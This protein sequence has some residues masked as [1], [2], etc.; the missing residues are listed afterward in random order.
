MG[1]LLTSLGFGLITASILAIA[2]VGFTLQFGITNLL[3]L[4]YGDVMTGAA[5]SAYLVRERGG[6]IWLTVIVGCAFGAAFSVLLNRFLY[7]RFARRGLRLFGMIIVTLAASIIIQ[8]SLQ[9]IFRADFFSLNAPT[10]KTYHFAGMLMTRSQLLIIAM[11]VALMAAVHVLLRFT[12]LGKAM[13]AT[14]GNADLARSCGIRTDRIVDLAWLLSGALCGIAGVTLV[15]N[16][17]TFTSATGGSFLIP[18]IAASILGGVGHP[19]GA[20]LGALVIGI[21]TEMTA[22]VISPAYKQVVAFAI[23]AAVLILRPTGILSQVATEKE[24]TT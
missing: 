9:A 20:M 7:A 11:A 3:N 8:N 12:R 14:S 2:S 18:I 10:G 22:T 24:V 21:S 1:S 16:L 5:F 13:R 15:I 4:A 19:Y 17:A 23:L 6:A